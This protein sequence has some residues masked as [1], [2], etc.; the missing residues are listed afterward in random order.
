MERIMECDTSLLHR[1]SRTAVSCLF[2]EWL[3][4]DE[5]NSQFH[6]SRQINRGDSR[7]RQSSGCNRFSDDGLL[8]IG[9]SVRDCTSSLST[10]LCAE[11]R[12]WDQRL[13]SVMVDIQVACVLIRKTG[14]SGL[15]MFLL[16]FFETSVLSLA[17]MDEDSSHF[18]VDGCLLG[19]LRSCR[20]NQRCRGKATLFW[21]DVEVR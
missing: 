16:T 3:T 19:W 10:I 2:C 4:F 11:V 9:R 17:L 7:G 8:A 21:S 18:T 15:K 1:P 14:R 5:S 20:R 12:K 13:C 6:Q